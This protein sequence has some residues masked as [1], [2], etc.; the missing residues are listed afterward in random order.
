VRVAKQLKEELGLNI[1]QIN[2]PGNDHASTMK[3]IAENGG[4]HAEPGNGVSGTNTWQVYEDQPEIPAFVY[5]SEVSHW[6]GDKLYAHGGGTAFSGGGWGIY[7]DDT[8]WVGGTDI[9]Q[10][11]LV[12]SS[13]QQ[14]LSNRIK[15]KFPGTDPFN[16][17]L[18][19][20]HEGRKFSVGDTVIYGYCVLQIFVTR[21]WHAVVAG[22]EDDDPRL[23]GIF[24]Q[25]NNLVDKHG[26][27]LGE[28][29]VIEMLG[30]V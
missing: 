27:L 19:L 1:S 7:P 9:A 4:T 20:F 28:K 18:T 17:N 21:G 24:D 14:A 2:V 13:L 30:N 16:Y 26:H 6:L 23:L 8:L 10:D 12:G 15:A 11:A 25:G 22:I 3:I 5:V 29:A